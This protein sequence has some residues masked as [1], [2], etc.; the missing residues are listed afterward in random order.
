[1]KL[2]IKKKENLTPRNGRGGRD[3]ERDDRDT[4]IES[5]REEEPQA[6]FLNC[7]YYRKWQE[8]RQNE[9]RIGQCLHL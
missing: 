2:R 5:D 6:F 1:M 9:V 3:R 7:G 8:G 4:E